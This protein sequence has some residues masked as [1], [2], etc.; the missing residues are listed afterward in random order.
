MSERFDVSLLESG[1]LMKK[2]CK[3]LISNMGRV[4][5][6]ITIVVAALVLF[7]DIGFA[8]VGMESF[9]ATLSVMLI[10]SY[11]MYFS[12]ENSGERLG[13]DTEEY[14]AS[15]NKYGELTLLIGGERIPHLREFCRKYSR[16]ELK[17]RRENL[18]FS[19]GYS[20]SEYERFK[21]GIIPP[22]IT[23]RHRRAYLRADLMKAVEISP[24][25]LL[26]PEKMSRRSELENPEN[27]KILK[28]LLGLVPTSICM[29]ATVSIMFTAKE[30][31]SFGDV[32]DGIF[33]LSTLLIIGFRGYAAGYNYKKNTVTLWNE[34]KSRLLGAFIKIPPEDFCENEETN[35][36]ENE[37]R[38]ADFR[39]YEKEERECEKAPCPELYDN[40]KTKE[41][42][43][44]TPNGSAEKQTKRKLFLPM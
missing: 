29:A 43:T 37:T 26:S 14:K 30:N 27:S 1:E 41:N 24:K 42:C 36:S 22:D 8:D 5:A 44:E 16:A 4:I 20:Y 12:L 15:K 33:K 35:D 18:L 34:T 2:G 32:M 6:I 7:T 10:S 13:E 28:M 39:A 9:T 17:Y 3:T 31:L 21:K 11:V 25:E 23:P 40:H 19:Y 38:G